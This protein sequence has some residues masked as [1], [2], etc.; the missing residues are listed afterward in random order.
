[1]YAMI[2]KEGG[3]WGD[4][5][6]NKV[7]VRHA[8]GALEVDALGVPVTPKDTAQG[9]YVG[10]P[11]A[12]FTLG[13]NNTI[14]YKNFSVSFLID[15]RFGGK[16]ISVTQAYLDI[17]GYSKASAD[18]RDNGGVD[19]KAEL[20][21]G[22]PYVGTTEGK[23]PAREYYSAFGNRSGAAGEYAYDATNVRLREFS[24][25]YRLPVKIKGIR[26]VSLSFVGRNLFF[27]SKKAPF[28]PDL[29][30]STG[31]ALQGIDVFGLPSTRSY[32]L[33]LK[34]GF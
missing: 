27:I 5:Y 2:L 31:N 7:A 21:D 32:G 24:V 19:V 26:S 29:A 6:A 4:I 28:D 12:K 30:M 8:N 33:N 10:N 13:W 22:T 23:L 34:V 3:S 25:G 18:A 11:Q 17:Y 1:M 15:G 16:V 14:D 9:Q 20:A